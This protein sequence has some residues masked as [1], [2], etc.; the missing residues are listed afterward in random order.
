MLLDDVPPGLTAAW[1]A[2]LVGLLVSAAVAAVDL[3][4]GGRGRRA[5]YGLAL[6]FASLVLVFVQEARAA[7]DPTFYLTPRSGLLSPFHALA[8]LFWNLVR[9][10]H[11][12]LLFGLLPALWALLLGI[13]FR[14][15]SR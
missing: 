9:T 7:A 13:I 4:G 10:A 8:A 14:R 12:L 1:L 5:P 3:A 15:G 2:S 11:G 6:A